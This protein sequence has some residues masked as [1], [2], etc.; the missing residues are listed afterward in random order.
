MEGSR[1]GQVV[2][3]GEGG[4]SQQKGLRAKKSVDLIIYPG[5]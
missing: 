3:E 5:F 2:E 4:I 1:G